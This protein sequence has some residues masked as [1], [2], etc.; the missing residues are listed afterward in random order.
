MEIGNWRIILDIHDYDKKC[1]VL[2]KDV[3]KILIR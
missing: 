2:Q 3:P 1:P